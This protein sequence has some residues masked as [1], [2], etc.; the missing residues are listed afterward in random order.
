LWKSLKPICQFV[1]RRRPGKEARRSSSSSS[2]RSRSPSP[3]RA[4]TAPEPKYV[5]LNRTVTM[6]LL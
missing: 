2:S 6:H 5:H 4:K 1:H 3:K